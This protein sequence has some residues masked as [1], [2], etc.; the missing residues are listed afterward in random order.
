[1]VITLDGPALREAASPESIAAMVVGEDDAAFEL[2]R[3]RILTP[4][5]VGMTRGRAFSVVLDR[6]TDG[7]ASED[8]VACFGP[9]A[10]ALPLYRRA[11]TVFAD[12]VRV[13]ELWSWTAI[14]A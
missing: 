10:D 3:H 2:V 14:A 1:L 4:E 7:R 8:D 5:S 6:L 11:R 9:Y 12:S 13:H